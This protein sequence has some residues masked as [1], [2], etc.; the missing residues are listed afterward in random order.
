MSGKSGS[1]TRKATFAARLFSGQVPSPIGWPFHERM[2]DDTITT[3]SRQPTRFQRV[4]ARLSGS[5]SMAEGGLL[6]SHASQHASASNG[7]RFACP[8][9]LP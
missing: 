5:S 2:T 7:A 9:H 1:R 4:P 6:E 3:A 8:V